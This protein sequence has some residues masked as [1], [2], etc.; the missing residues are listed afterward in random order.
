M[1]WT[2]IFQAAGLAVA[3]QQLQHLC[4]GHH[5]ILT[6]PHQ[7]IHC[8]VL[9]REEWLRVARTTTS[10]G[11]RLSHN[12]SGNAPTYVTEVMEAHPFVCP[13]SRCTYRFTGHVT[14]ANISDSNQ[15]IV[16]YWSVYGDFSPTLYIVTSWWWATS[17]F[18]TCKRIVT[19]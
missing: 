19:E 6:L 4:H 18:E 11:R 12:Y 1:F 7:T 15:I 5:V 3:H 9:S 10:C 2:N 17:K 16:V 14:K 8:G 13:A